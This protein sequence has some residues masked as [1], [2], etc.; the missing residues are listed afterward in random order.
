VRRFAHPWE[1]KASLGLRARDPA[2]LAAYGAHGR[3]SGGSRDDAL[4]AAFALWREHREAGRSVILTAG[5]H[6][7]VDEL[8]LRAR[9]VRVGAG[10]VEPGGIRSAP[11]ASGWAMRW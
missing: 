10:E 8:A 4:D 3:L 6:V 5:D 9:A 1:A 11:S 7:T 2:A